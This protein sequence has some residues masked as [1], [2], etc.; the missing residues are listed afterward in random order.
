MNQEER[1]AIAVINIAIARRVLSSEEGGFPIQVG[2]VA[3]S[4]LDNLKMLLGDEE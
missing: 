3:Y 1:A 2:T 4:L